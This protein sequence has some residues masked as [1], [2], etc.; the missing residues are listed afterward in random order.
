MMADR[1][2]GS[3]TFL[4]TDIEGSTRLWEQYPTE[5]QSALERHD[6]ILRSAIAGHGGYVFSTAG[7]AFAAAFDRAGDAVAAA[8]AAQR[9]LGSE[10]S[11]A[12]RRI[13]GLR[14][15]FRLTAPTALT[16]RDS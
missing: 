9:A 16:A 2:T 5:R 14:W 15:D 3:V 13:P 1:P 4:F 8:V 12:D 10:P 11:P 7:D 6:E